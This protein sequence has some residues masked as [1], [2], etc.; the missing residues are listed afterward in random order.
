MN[1][2]ITIERIIPAPREEVFSFNS[3]PELLEKWCF[4]EGMNLRVPVFE[5]REGGKYRFEHSN[6]ND[7]YICSGHFE[8]FIPHEKM[9]QIENVV[10]AKKGPIHENI[11]TEVVF[12]DERNGTKLSVKQSGL[13]S[14]AE[15]DECKKAWN[16][17]LDNLTNLLTH[18]RFQ[19]GKDL[20]SQ[21]VSSG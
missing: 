8:E 10:S 5:A 4:P 7:V 14:Q 16:E 17:C 19:P 15:A 13:N 12:S 1:H 9:V 3:K 20:R 2:K 21:Q 6:E 18:Q 11:R